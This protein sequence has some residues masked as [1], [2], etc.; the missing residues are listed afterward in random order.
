M[1]AG[2][3]DAGGVDLGVAGVGERRALLVGAPDGGGVA[4]LGVGGQVEDV[5][6]AAGGQHHR[7]G[8]EGLH[9]AG[10]HVPGDDALGHSVHHH[11]LLH[12]VAGEHLHLAQAD[13]ALQGLVGAQQQ[14]LAG[15]APGVEGAAHQGAAEGAVVQQPAVF[16]GE[17]HALGHAL[18]DDV[19]RHLGQAVDVGLPGPEVAALDRVVE[20][21]EGAVAVVAVVLG[22]VDAALGGDGVG[23]ARAVLVAEAEDFVAQ[24]GQGGGG[25]RRRPGRSPRR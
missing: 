20:Q 4:A 3:R 2:D 7:V 10:D 21:A 18:V 8:H 1:V 24:L 25:R 15:L 13:L 22:G 23:P 17:G 5:A 19:H 6:V 16:P 11:Q 14:L 12:L 9:L